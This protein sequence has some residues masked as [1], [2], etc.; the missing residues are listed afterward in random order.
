MTRSKQTQANPF[1]NDSPKLMATNAGFLARGGRIGGVMRPS[2]YRPGTISLREIRRYQQST[3]L[4]I[5]KAAFRRLVRE[6][7][8]DLKVRFQPSAIIAL[9]E[10]AEA[11]IVDL[12]VSA[13]LLAIHSRRVTIKV[14]DMQIA[15]RMRKE[16]VEL[17]L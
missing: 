6:I 3:E 13:C 5:P 14:E 12:F 2:R 9:Q 16:L 17:L 10:D 4:L 15:H 8:Q 1:A 11:F 7:G